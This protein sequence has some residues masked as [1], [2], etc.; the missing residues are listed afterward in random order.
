V[1]QK[2]SFSEEKFQ[3]LLDKVYRFLSFRPRS[4]KEI[5]DYFKKR[6]IADDITQKLF[7][8]LREQQLID[9]FAFAQ[10]WVEQRENFRPKGKIGLKVELKQKGINT[11]II[12]KILI[13][14]DE[15]A[16]AKKA[17]QKKIKIYKKLPPKEFYQKISTFL[18]SRGFSWPTIKK[19]IEDYY[20]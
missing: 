7:K 10:W 19:I 9:D 3:K 14:V 18:S 15:I 12:E 8:I 20:H 13:Q 5:T 4:E 11:Q 17:V 6:K 16:L 2:N 1:K